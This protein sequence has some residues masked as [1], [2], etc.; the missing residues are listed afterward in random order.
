MIYA[1]S[2]GPIPATLG[3]EL[4]IMYASEDKAYTLKKP[5]EVSCSTNKQ[6]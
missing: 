3:R 1:Y 2:N 4:A 6:K 5:S